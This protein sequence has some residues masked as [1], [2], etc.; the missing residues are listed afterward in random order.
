MHNNTVTRTPTE[1]PRKVV[2]FCL[3]TFEW[4]RCTS[5]FLIEGV[6]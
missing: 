5:A 4:F 6:R 1:Y 2:F 3:I